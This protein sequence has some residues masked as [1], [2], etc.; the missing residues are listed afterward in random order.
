VSVKGNKANIDKINAIVDM[1]PPQSRK[2]VQRLRQNRNA[3]PIHGK[4][5]RAKLTIFQSTQRL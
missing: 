1:K 4:T 2:E 5:S 3:E